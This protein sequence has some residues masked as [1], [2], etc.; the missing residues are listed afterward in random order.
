MLIDSHAHLFLEQFNEDLAST[1]ERAKQSGV[2]HIFMPNIDS[3][4]LKPLLDTCEAYKDICYPMI[5]LHP[6]SVGDNYLDELAV[7]DAELA[8]PNNYVAIG[9]IG[10]DLYWDKTFVNEQIVAFEHQIKLALKYDLPIV[11]HLRDSFKEIVQTLSKYKNEPL[12]G[13]FHSFGG[14]LDEASELLSFPGFMLGINGVVTFKNSNLSEVLVDVSLSR[15]VVETDSPYLAPVTYRGKRN[16]S[17]YVSSVAQKLA[18]IYDTEYRVV[19]NI[20][21]TNALKVFGMTK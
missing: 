12:R 6:T 1:I 5:G 7:I 17:A 15:I 9:E 4:T 10:V 14:T 16:E 13:I 20:T 3:S 2:T 19:A 21:S 11:I 18:E 8:K